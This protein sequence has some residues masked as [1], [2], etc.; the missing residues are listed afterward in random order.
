MAQPV[1]TLW[2]GRQLP[3]EPLTTRPRPGNS[4]LESN[5]EEEVTIKKNKYYFFITRVI[6]KKKKARPSSPSRWMNLFQHSGQDNPSGVV[7][8]RGPFSWVDNSG[9][10]SRQLT[11]HLAWQ[12]T[13]S[14]A[15]RTMSFFI[16]Y[17]Y[18]YTYI[19]IYTYIY[20]YITPSNTLAWQA[21]TSGVSRHTTTARLSSPPSAISFEDRIGTGPPR[22]RTEVIYVDLG[23]WAIRPRLRGCSEQRGSVLNTDEFIHEADGCHE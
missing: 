20:I 15:S 18:I 17:I 3:R 19:H 5:K 13:T 1:P 16:I 22:A 8:I 2:R 23:Y 4:R 7:S 9:P 12:A 14:G 21:T 10:M 11:P 6:K